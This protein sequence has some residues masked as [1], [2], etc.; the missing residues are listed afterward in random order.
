MEL[1]LTKGRPFNLIIKFTIPL[2]LGNLFQQLYNMADSVIVGKFVGAGA[3]AAVG[4]TGT[5][6][7]LVL[8]IVIGMTTGFSV[9]TSQYYGA[10]DSQGVRYSVTGGILMS[11]IFG[12]IVMIVSL[13]F[14]PTL[15]SIMNTPDDIYEDALIYIDIICAGTFASLFYN[16]FAAYLRAIGNSRVP[17][18]FLVFSACLNVLLDLLLILVF[19][20]GV[21]GA[22]TATISSQGISAVLCAIYIC[23]SVKILRPSKADWRIYLPCWKKQLSIGIPMALETGITASGTVI[24]QTALNIYGTMSIAGSTAAYKIIDFLIEG[25]Y[26]LGQ[27]MASYAGQNYGAGDTKRII[28]G[29]RAGMKIN[30]VYSV[31]AAAAGVVFLPFLIRLF[32]AGDVPME[33]VMPWAK[34]AVYECGIMYIP[35][36]MI[37]IYR[38]TLQGCGYSLQAM[39]MGVTELA[40]RIVLAIISMKVESYPLAIA[41]DALAWLCAGILGWILYRILIYKKS[42]INY[43]K[44]V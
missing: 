1:N 35:L 38:N 30:V 6:M 37:F 42:Q 41:A 11:L 40:S 39:L 7:F 9:M 2:F 26:S 23:R 36:G 27:T 20:M 18:F 28:E 8:G 14:M 19:K 17:L 25:M 5:I 15:L 16:L 22:A 34:I 3:L 4:S 31:I 44:I 13:T 32:F 10:G 24:M 43:I 33:A 29:T 21:A 12:L